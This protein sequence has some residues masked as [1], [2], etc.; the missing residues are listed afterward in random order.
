MRTASAWLALTLVVTAWGTLT[1]VTG[2]AWNTISLVSIRFLFGIAEA[3]AYPGSARAI[4]DWLPSSERGRA[5]GILFSGSRLSGAVSFPLLVFLLTRWQWRISFAILGVIG[6]CWAAC[7][8][9]SFRDAR[10]AEPAPPAERRDTGTASILRSGA[11]AAAMGQYFASNFIFFMGLSWMLPY[12]RK[13]FGLLDS[14]AALYAMAPLLAGASS[15]W[16]AGWLVDRLY[17]SRFRL[18]SRAAPAMIGFAI[19]VA[20]LLALT[21]AATAAAAAACFTLAVFG[22]DMTVS[23]SWVFCA[24]RAGKQAG[25]ISGAMNMVGNI[26]SIV[27]A[28][29]FPILQAFTGRSGTYFM[30]AA[31]LN[32]AGFLCWF[33][34]RLAPESEA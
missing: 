23:P 15:Q 31:G 6:F 3:G 20:G 1:A 30:V 25:M 26:G 13:Q 22:S 10:P 2:A 33:G 16:I 5:N 18:W 27:S 32:V 11:L 19:S 28:N 4:C 12:L 21:G 14:T 29:A 8:F 34:M 9:T 24:D 7:W 17:R